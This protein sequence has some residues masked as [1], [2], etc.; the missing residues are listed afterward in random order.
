MGSSQNTTSKKQITTEDNKR[1]SRRSVLRRT[2]MTGS[3]LA[4]GGVALSGTA[5]ATDSIIKAVEFKGCSEVWIVLKR[6]RSIYPTI[7]IFNDKTKRFEDR[8]LCVMKGDFTRIPG[9]FGDCPVFKFSVP[10]G[11][12][13][14]GVRGI[15]SFD[16]M[17]RCAEN[18]MKK[19]H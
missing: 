16:N 15:G 13:I 11:F 3:T 19:V 7:K 10:E 2:A 9:Q 1:F 14:V 12:K 8:D 17:N 18:A 6:P 4:I 5:A